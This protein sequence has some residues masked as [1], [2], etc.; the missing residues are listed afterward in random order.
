MHVLAKQRMY[1]HP[2][3]PRSNDEPFIPPWT[4]HADP[5]AECNAVVLP[6]DM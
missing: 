1:L 6:L 3:Y 2:T 5:V 4:Y